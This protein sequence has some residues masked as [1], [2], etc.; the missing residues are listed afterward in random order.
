MDCEE[1]LFSGMVEKRVL[2]VEVDLAVWVG[3]PSKSVC[4]GVGGSR[5]RLTS[6]L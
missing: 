4:S 3:D 2:Q 1:T 6:D 5:N